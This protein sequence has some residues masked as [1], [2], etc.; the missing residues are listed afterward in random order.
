M[1]GKTLSRKLNYTKMERALR[2]LAVEERLA[3][4]ENLAVMTELEICDLVVQTYE[5]AYVTDEEIGLVRK[6]DVPKYTQLVKTISR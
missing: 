4:I 3:D 1:D 6:E 2:Y 5:V